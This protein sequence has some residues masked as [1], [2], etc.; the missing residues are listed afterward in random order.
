[1][2][3]FANRPYAPSPFTLTLT[4]SPQGR[5]NQT[6]SHPQYQPPLPSPHRALTRLDSRFHGNDGKERG[7]GEEVGGI[8][9]LTLPA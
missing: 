6:P 7:N 4:L 9:A 1:M 3:R 8:D 5:G 2:G